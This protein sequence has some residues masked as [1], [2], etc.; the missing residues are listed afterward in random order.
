MSVLLIIHSYRFFT[1]D[2]LCH[3]MIYEKYSLLRMQVSY[4]PKQP[5]YDNSKP[6]PLPT[7]VTNSDDSLNASEHV[8]WPDALT[9]KQLDDYENVIYMLAKV[10]PTTN[11]IWLELARINMAKNKK[12]VKTINYLDMSHILEPQE[13]DVMCPRILIEAPLWDEFGK[14]RQ[15]RMLRQL[16][17]VAPI[18]YRQNYVCYLQIV[19]VF[20]LMSPRARSEIRESLIHMGAS[21]TEWYADL[22]L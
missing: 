13:P 7:D 21:S 16:N 14:F 1:D 20:A 18:L 2:V 6:A 5:S 8:F 11:N 12:L 10:E 4:K 3:G 19:H 22:K 15:Q 9:Q 17:M